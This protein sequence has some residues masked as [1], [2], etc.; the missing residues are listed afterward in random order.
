MR[1]PSRECPL[2]GRWSSDITILEASLGHHL[3]LF[4]T[5][6]FRDLTC[7][8]MYIKKGAERPLFYFAT[9]LAY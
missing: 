5:G 3:V 2:R 4:L 7:S 1:V 9:M 8:I 6:Y